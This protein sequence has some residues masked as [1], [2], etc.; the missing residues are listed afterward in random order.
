MSNVYLR[1]PRYTAAFYRNRDEDNILTEF[2]PIDFCKVTPEYAILTHYLYPSLGA[3]GQEKRC[4]SQRSWN[5][6]LHGKNASGDKQIINRDPS[7]WLTISEISLLEN[8]SVNIRQVTYDY[9]CIKT[10]PEVC[11]NRQVFNIDNS[12]TLKYA[13]AYTLADIMQREFF[14]VI[15]DWIKKDKEYCTVNELPFLKMSSIEGFLASY[16]I[17]I[18]KDNHE[19]ETLKRNVNRFIRSSKGFCNDKYFK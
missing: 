19:R 12:F 11:H 15:I 6:L 10:P 14:R 18:S 5:N 2:M 13:Q 3:E 17:P 9:L 4:Y 7:K 8:E 1:L 16:D